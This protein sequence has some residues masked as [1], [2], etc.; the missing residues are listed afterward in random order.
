MDL[1]FDI[2]SSAEFWRQRYPADRAPRVQL[3]ASPSQCAARKR[4]IEP[5]LPNW[6]DASFL[7]PTEGI[8]HV[9]D[10]HGRR[11]RRAH[12]FEAHQWKGPIPEGSFCKYNENVYVESPAFMFMHAATLL[13]LTALIAFGDEL[14][15][16]YSFD[17]RQE[18]GFRKRVA[19]LTCRKEI[20][21]FLLQ[22]K[23]CRG[24][25]LALRALPFVIDG[26]ASPM[27]TFDEMTMCLPFRYGGYGVPTP[28]MNARV[29][30]SP[31]AARI[32]KQGKC[33]LDMGYM[34]S[35]LDVEHHGSL[36]HSSEEDRASDRARVNALR[37]MGF[38]VVELTADQ[39]GDLFAYEYIIEHIAKTVGKRLPKAILGATPQ[40]LRLRKALYAW[41]RSSGKLR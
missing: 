24:Q 26:S 3:G 6:V 41:N 23:G 25:R 30:L 10:I 17:S 20:E 15:G 38:E 12:S 22:A 19:P 7:E 34:D 11:T 40:R 18:R 4:E 29:T 35:N 14:C 27:E 37:E 31:R 21:H 39:V 16:Q 13:D 8:V 33:Y 9:L 32:A 36:D 28:T 2:A 1:V 5:L